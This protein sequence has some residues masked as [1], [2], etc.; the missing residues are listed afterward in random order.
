[1]LSIVTINRNNEE[2]LQKTLDSLRTQSAQNFQW[3]FI[4]GASSDG[5]VQL[6]RTFARSEDVVSSESDT[7]IYNAMNKGIAKSKGEYLLFLNSGDIFADADSVQTLINALSGSDDLVL[8]GFS[9]RNKVRMPKPIW[10]CFWSLP[11]SHQ[12]IVYRR[13]LLE[14]YGFLE[15]Y[16]FAAD[17]EHFL[18]I[19]T[20]P[21]RVLSIQKLLVINEPYGSDQNLQVVLSEYR[22]ALESNG[23]SRL[24]AALIYHFKRFYLGL[25]L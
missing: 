21:L 8:F 11:T 25:V 13:S 4:D 23:Y 6:G 7:G 12:A 5:S 10:S 24:V 19:M 20:Q 17:F 1:M 9:V 15:S 3:V 16:R 2:G 22:K 18:R 14:R